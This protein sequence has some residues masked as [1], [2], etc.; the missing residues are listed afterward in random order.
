MKFPSS[1]FGCPL[2][3]VVKISLFLY[4]GKHFHNYKPCLLIKPLY[5]ISSF[6]SHLLYWFCLYLL[7]FKVVA[8]LLRCIKLF[9]S[10]PYK[11][12]TYIVRKWKH[13]SCLH[14]L[15]FGHSN[16]WIMSSSQTNK[17]TT[18]SQLSNMCICIIHLG[19]NKKKIYWPLNWLL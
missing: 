19:Q 14:I 2:Q 6:F 18:L 16:C 5:F 17:G 1:S 13:D 10:P 15:I 8:C 11:Q 9:L 12:G 7:T 4:E 3:N